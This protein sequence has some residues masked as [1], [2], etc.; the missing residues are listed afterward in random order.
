MT[1]ENT[2]RLPVR[3]VHA[4]TCGEAWEEA[5]DYVLEHGVVNYHPFYDRESV[6][7]TIIANVTEPLEEPRFSMGD[8]LAFMDF[9]G[10]VMGK[11]KIPYRDTPY[12]RKVLDGTE[13]E[14]LE[15]GKSD[16]TYHDRLFANR[17]GMM[18]T[19]RLPDRLTNSID[20]E[21]LLTEG[22]D[23]VAGIIERLKETPEARNALGSTWYPERDI[24]GDVAPPCLQ[25]VW[26]RIVDGGLVMETTWRSRDL[27]RAWAS[28]AVG[29]T[30]LGRHVADELGV[31]LVQYVD[32]SMSCHVYRGTDGEVYEKAR[33][34]VSIARR[35]KGND[36]PVLLPHE[37]KSQADRENTIT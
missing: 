17:R 15:T 26:F 29:M 18:L 9:K 22:T 10:A 27:F 23:Q 11:N 25:T 33:D 5:L 7:A 37:R 31:E 35:R 6:E 32:F 21:E 14:R 28:N 2:T 3:V 30:E 12:V 36:R 1:D 4:R 8:E 20:V 24:P 19:N 16:Y 13:D 34:A